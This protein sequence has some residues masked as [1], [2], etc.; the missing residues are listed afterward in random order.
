MNKELKKEWCKALRDEGKHKGLYKQGRVH[1]NNNNEM[2]CCLGVLCEIAKVPK[3]A[4]TLQTGI[5]CYDDC[6]TT[7]G[8]KLS[9]KLGL[10]YKQAAH[11]MGEND[12]GISFGAIA[13]WIE[14]N[15]IEEEN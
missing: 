3:K 5:Y 14:S 2:Y 11:L 9:N 13:N 15:V 4:H 7:I 10:P 12:S 1:L 6:F 8:D